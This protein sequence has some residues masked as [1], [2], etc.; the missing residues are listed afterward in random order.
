MT[1]IL[2]FIFWMLLTW[3][4]ELL[5]VVAGIIVALIAALVSH[6]IVFHRGAGRFLN[7]VRWGAAV[8][9]LLYFA[10][11]EIRANLDLAFRVITG[12]IKPALIEIN[13]NMERD[14]SRTLLG[15]AITLTP[16]TMTVKTGSR[17]LIHWINYNKKDKP[18]AVFE[19]LGRMITE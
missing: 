13:V 2:T 9:F 18:G 12:R 6:K 5:E 4:F 1:F 10:Y 14:S 15:N 8:L 16:G 7:P 19:K 3:S 11:A 17:F